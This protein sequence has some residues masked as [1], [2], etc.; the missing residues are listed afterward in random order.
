MSLSAI[1][2]HIKTC[3]ES[4]AAW[5][6]T[7]PA[8]TLSDTVRVDPDHLTT[9]L[10]DFLNRLQ[11]NY[12]YFHPRYAGQMLKPP[13]PVAVL[14]YLSAMLIN[15]NN[16]ALD[17]SPATSAMERECIRQL[18]AM[19]GFDTPLG[20]LTGGGT[21]ANLEALWVARQLHP[22]KAIVFSEQA[23]YTHKRMGELIQAKIQSVPALPTG[24]MDLEALT[25]ML[26]RGEV[27]TVVATLGSTALGALDN[28]HALVELKARY[29][30]R[31]HVDTAYGG[32][33]SVLAQTD[34]A[35]HEYKAIAQCDSLVIDPHKHGL[36]PYGCGCVL[37]ADPAV[38]QLYHHD[39]PYTYFTSD[40]LHLGEISL[41]CSRSGAVAAALWLTLQCF[42]LKATSGFGPILK[43][44]RQTALD[45]AKWLE[46]NA[47][48]E[49]HVPPQLDIVTYYPKAATTHAVSQL[50]DSIFRQ[51]M[52]AKDDP[53]YLAKLNISAE[54][55]QA[56]HPEVKTDSDT[57]TVFRSCFLKPE[58]GEAL[59]VITGALMRHAESV[60]KQSV[61][62]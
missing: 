13:H 6:R 9:V 53:L 12:P 30:F 43:Q 28:L 58:H 51:A 37:F 49:L 41:E 15:P 36:Q 55:F 46:G 10:N 25:P 38:G 19:F 47:L 14:G 24:Q 40:D 23:H 54:A 45:F 21:V 34:P 35:F 18:G 4:I 20:H 26:E 52:T 62:C 59:D 1:E 60:M 29:G 27:G 33:Y 39:S 56:L 2:P 16:H 32:F 22:E 5:E 42:P 31:I 7:W 61:S 57:V 44:C 3:I 17:S 48:Y 11:D 8:F 50:T